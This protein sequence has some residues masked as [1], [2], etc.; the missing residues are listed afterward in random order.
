MKWSNRQTTHVNLKVYHLRPR[1]DITFA[2]LTATLIEISDMKILLVLTAFF[3]IIY[4][5]GQ[6]VIATK[7]DTLSSKIIFFENFDNNKHNWTVGT[8]KDAGA[9]I[10]GG[11]YYLT[12]LGHAYGE[13]KDINI[14]TRKNFEI[15]TR[16]KIVSG[17]TEHKDYYSML[18]WGRA[19]MFGYYFT[20]AKDGFASIE[21]CNSKNQNS[22]TVKPGSFQKTM[23]DPNE[24]NVYT[25]RKTG[26][27]Y[28][29]YINR[30]EFYTMP[31]TP[32]YGN[33]I[34][35]GAGRKVSLAIDYLKVAYL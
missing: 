2:I 3:T 26:N 35:V 25:I 28:T 8:N 16:I 31:F 20:F 23:L 22:C 10:E 1:E 6:T 13:A 32:F 34:G 5:S 12:A 15:E 18:F 4:C 30:T 21:V 17:K 7:A 11:F 14:D 33:L 19:A 24:F 9:K 29:F 27:T